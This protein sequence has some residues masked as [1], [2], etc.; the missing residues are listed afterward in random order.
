MSK[1]GGSMSISN[2]A[3]TNHWCTSLSVMQA[4]SIVNHQVKTLIFILDVG[5]Q[6]PSRDSACHCCS[7]KGHLQALCQSKAV[8][9][10]SDNDLQALESYLSLIQFLKKLLL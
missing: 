3:A 5:N 9:A 1:D 2:L 6:Y 8:D 4:S 10:I 7:K